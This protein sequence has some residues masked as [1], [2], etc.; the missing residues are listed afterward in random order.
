MNEFQSPKLPVGT[1]ALRCTTIPI[2]TIRPNGEW[3]D[4][5]IGNEWVV[6]CTASLNSLKMDY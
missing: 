3:Y 2:G 6:L 4:I 1:P 5:F